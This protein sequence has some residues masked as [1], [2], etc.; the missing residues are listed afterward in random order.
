MRYVTSS[1]PGMLVALWALVYLTVAFV[2]LD[3][4][5]PV[6][7]VLGSMYSMGLL[8]L[9]VAMEAVKRITRL[10]RCAVTLICIGLTAVGFYLSV[11][12]WE[13]E[14]DIELADLNGPDISGTVT[15]FGVWRICSINL[16][17]LMLTSLISMWATWTREEM[18]FLIVFGFVQ[19][20]HV[21]DLPSVFNRRSIV[22]DNDCI[23]DN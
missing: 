17:M 13:S 3:P 15:K 18:H 5:S 10:M 6:S 22:G 16:G 21:L 23:V 11:Y 9:F 20:Q 8:F 1:A 4:N 7:G 2:A 12:V 14:S 19:R